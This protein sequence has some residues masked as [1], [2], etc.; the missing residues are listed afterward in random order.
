MDKREALI[1]E[2]LT[3]GEADYLLSGGS[4]TG[5][6]EMPG[7]SDDASTASTTAEHAAQRGARQDSDFAERDAELRDLRERHARLDERMRIFR[8]AAEQPESQPQPKQKP[9]R[10]S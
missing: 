1:A 10:E 4:N 8:E 9:D 5:R 3:E 6:L 2:G 7:P